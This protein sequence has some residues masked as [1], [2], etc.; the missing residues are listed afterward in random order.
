MQSHIDRKEYDKKVDE[1]FRKMAKELELAVITGENPL[2]EAK[3][4]L[5]LFQH[6]ISSGIPDEKQ[7]R[8]NVELF[9]FKG[10]EAK[11]LRQFIDRLGKEDEG[12]ILESCVN[13]ED[14]KVLCI[15]KAMLLYFA[16]LDKAIDYIMAHEGKL[17]GLDADIELAP[18]L[19]SEF[20]TYIDKYKE[21]Y[22]EWLV[23]TFQIAK[24]DI[25]QISGY[26]N[27]DAVIVTEIAE[28]KKLL[29]S[30]VGDRKWE[31]L[32]K[33]LEYS[34]FNQVEEL[35]QVSLDLQTG[36]YIKILIG[37][38]QA[39]QEL[40]GK[41]Q[42]I[43]KYID[44]LESFLPVKERKGININTF[45]WIGTNREV[46]V[47]FLYDMLSYENKFISND[48]YE[49]F[50]AAFSG[51]AITKE[52]EIRWMALHLDGKNTAKSSLFYLFEEL[53]LNKFIGNFEVT[54][55]AILN[56]KLRAIFRDRNGKELKNFSQTNQQIGRI[57]LYSEEIK[58]IVQGIPKNSG[59]K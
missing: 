13:N 9:N 21:L 40:A 47:K 51:D 14:F 41:T 3:E 15:A 53:A 22:Y 26:K 30:S 2:G 32:T 27:E 52:L 23:Q 58:N 29:S 16:K 19:L 33:R 57:P 42:A 24:V 38:N 46:Q 4:R 50:K 31:Y 34:D 59:I 45:T 8:E 5:E 20:K 44:Y 7:I 11:K 48:D 18:Y 10:A 43:K 1:V 56:S 35:Y 54:N 17:Q 36:R 12:L 25:S 39:R 55:K 37:M 49:K 6:V 28:F